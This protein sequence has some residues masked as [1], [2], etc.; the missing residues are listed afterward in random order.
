MK[1]KVIIAGIILAGLILLI[2]IQ[3]H[4]INKLSHANQIQAVEL[5]TLKD[6]VLIHK[7]KNNELTFKLASVEIEKSSLKESLDLMGIDRQALKERDIKWRKITAA[8]RAE[9]AATGHGETNV[10]DTFRI[11]KTDTIYFQKVNDWTNNYLSLFNAEIVNKK[12]NFDYTYK[13]KIDFITTGTRKE[14][15]VSV[16]LS[17]PKAQITTANSITIKNDKKW[18]ERPVIWTVVGIGAGVLITK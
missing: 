11:E 4:K 14:T 7:S 10:V 12:L 1:I 8:L 5:S 15:V 16:I 17:D 3:N 18:Y 2:I 6:S 9:L 13:T